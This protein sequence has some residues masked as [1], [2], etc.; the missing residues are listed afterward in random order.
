MATSIESTQLDFARIKESLKTHFLSTDEFADYDFDASALDSILDVLAYNTHYNGLVAN[1]ALNEAFLNTAQLRAS[2]LAI[3]ESLGYN[4]KSKSAATA[5]VNLSVT[6]TSIGRPSTISISANR[7]FTSAVDDVTYTF[8]TTQS[9]TA[10]DDGNGFY[11]F[12]TSDGSAD[13]PIYEGVLK[14]KTFVVSSN[15]NPIYI[16]PDENMDTSTAVVEVYQNRTST[17]FDTY[18]PYKDA[19]TITPQ[20]TFYGLREAPN[21]Y[22]ELYFG[23]GAVIGKKPAVGEVIIVTYLSTNSS[24]ANR[25]TTFTSQNT[26]TIDNVNYPIDVT[27]VSRAAGGSDKESITSIKQN[28]PI[29]FAAQNRLVTPEDYIALIKSNY[30]N[31]INDVTAWGGEDNVPPNYGKVYVALNYKDGTSAATKQTIQS[32]ITTRLTDG[33]AIMSIDTLFENAAQCFIETAVFFNFN[34]SITTTTAG[35]I[36]NQV[37][38]VVANYFTNNLNKFN[39]VFRRS[40]ILTEVDN[41]SEAIL[42]SRMD[43]KVQRR[44][45]PVLSQDLAYSVNFPVILSSPLDDEYV[46]TTNKFVYENQLCLIRNQLS[47]T[48]LQIVR[49]SDGAVLVNN[50]GSYTPSTGTINLVS[51][52]PTEIDGS[53]T[54]IRIS[55]IPAN[56]STVRPLRNFVL[57][58]DTTKSFAS[59]QIDYERI[60]VTI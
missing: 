37:N 38:N 19:F 12:L 43:V 59:A 4:P 23:D 41:L 26:V 5:I 25:A 24:A 53:I 30:G 6:N 51:F 2:V 44:F 54:D 39:E 49:N 40:S 9:Y 15:N 27:T 7:A 57:A 36:E 31:F 28:A 32:D 10:E 55:A 34:P 16:I 46:I 35:A 13:I 3:A 14:T 58:L 11:Q 52:N 45:T 60:R 22:Y 42:N 1:F 20:S 56:Q 48:T 29:Q 8:Y 33:R 21:G 50:I 17:V 18:L 47:S